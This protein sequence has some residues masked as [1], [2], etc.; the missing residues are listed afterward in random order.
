V[1]RRLFTA[2]AWAALVAA[3]PVQAQAQTQTQALAPPTMQAEGR[4]YAPGAF[5]GVEI[6][7]A[8]E[9]RY[10]QGDVDEVFVAGNSEVQR[11]VSVD[12]QG[13]KLR[14]RTASSWRFWS[15]QRLQVQVTSRQLSRL[16]IQGAADWL[17]TGPVNSERLAVFISG[18]GLARFDRL[19]CENLAFSV[20]GAGDGQF[21]GQV[22][23]LSVQIS[24]KSDFRGEH[25]QARTA[26]VTISGIGDV[27][28]WVLD[29]LGITVSG[30]GKVE[31]WGNPRVRER[32][33]GPATIDARGPRPPP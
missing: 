33:S 12:V 28:V 30:I 26:R 6:G 21:K 13:S 15:A 4:V 10:Q 19:N 20:S 2:G 32:T 3:A 25:L 5:D 14:I 8:A 29:E 27:K 16:S 11:S 17:A 1:K 23:D 7:G 18:A 31:Y 9:V 22:Q 24:G